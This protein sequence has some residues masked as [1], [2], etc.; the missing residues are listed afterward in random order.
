MRTNNDITQHV[1]LLINFA[2][3]AIQICYRTAN[4]SALPRS[5][6][7]TEK[8]ISWLVH[9]YERHSLINGVSI[10]CQELKKFKYEWLSFFSS[11]FKWIKG[12]KKKAVAWHIKRNYDIWSN[13]IATF[14]PHI[15]KF[16]F[17][18]KNFPLDNIVF[19]HLILNINKI[20]TDWFQQRE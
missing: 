5:S 2:Y 9:K 8:Y 1:L 13:F 14:S 12:V 20:Y 11:F 3:K 18:A 7:S 6:D 10:K 16:W 19:L 4:I 17:H 15:F